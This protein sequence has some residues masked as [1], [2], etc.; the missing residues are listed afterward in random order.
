MP[1]LRQQLDHLGE[2]GPDGLDPFVALLDVAEQLTGDA[3]R[4]WVP[5]PHQK[6]PKGHWTYWAM[7]AGRG[8]GKTEGGSRFVNAHAEGEPCMPGDVPHRIGIIAPTHPDARNTCVIGDSGL[9]QVNPKIDYRPGSLKQGDL[10]WPNGAVANLF[11]AYQPEDP[12]RLRGPQH[13]LLWCE[14]F[15]AWR[16]LED[17]WHM[18]RLGLRLGKYPRA[19]FTTTPRPRPLLIKIM[20]LPETRVSYATTD[21]NPHLAAPVRA[22]LYEAYGGTR[23]GQQELNAKM[24]TDAPGALWTRDVE[25]RADK[26]YIQYGAYPEREVVDRAGETIKEPDLSRI[27]IA[28]DPAVSTGENAAETGIV[29]CGA[30]YDKRGFVLG[31]YSIRSSAEKWARAAIAAYRTHKADCIV[32]EANNGGD[33]V[34]A[35]LRAIDPTVPVKL[36]YASRGKTIRAEP[37]AALYQQDRILHT[38]LFE[39]LEDQMCS[40]E[41]GDRESPDRMDALVWGMTDLLVDTS[42][43]GAWMTY[44]RGQLPAAKVAALVQ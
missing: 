2:R 5:L 7:I 15:A 42:D 22:A 3:E 28:V 9:L 32:A 31:D 12:E 39:E 43:S 33:L 17:T 36:V 29:A 6:P 30:S 41:Q 40:W 18:A 38:R 20:A 25:K 21:D 44:M 16:Y 10:K 11:G 35:T 34:A 23:L 19:I 4:I 14:E 24:L 37:V 26:G 1:T 13:C 8:S 27:V